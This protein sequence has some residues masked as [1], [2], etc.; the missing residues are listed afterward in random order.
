MTEHERS[1]L[2]ECLRDFAV[3][4]QKMALSVHFTE[5]FPGE[6]A[7]SKNVVSKLQEETRVYETEALRLATEILRLS[8]EREPIEEE[9]HQ[10]NNWC[11][12]C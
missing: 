7:E 10:A 5:T 12:A 11:F 8:L 1:Y 9:V 3:I 2:L 4:H 6:L